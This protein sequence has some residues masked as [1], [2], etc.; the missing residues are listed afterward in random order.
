M[1]W[2]SHHPPEELDRTWRLGGL[3]VCARCL[4]VYPVLLL[5]LVIQFALGA[6]LQ[7]RLDGM[8]GVV[9][10]MPALFDW[11]YGRWRPHAGSNLWRTSTG[12]L[13]GV[14]LARSLYVHLQRPF[15]P[16]LLAQLSLVGV[17]VVGVLLLGF[18]SPKARG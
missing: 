11:A 9:L 13:L 8:M 14:A 1:Y 16:V 15:P 5:G 3:H 17:V 10:T 2:L 7:L 4:G 12:V 6:P 18:F